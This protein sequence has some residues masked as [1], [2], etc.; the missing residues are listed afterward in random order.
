MSYQTLVALYATAAAASSAAG[1]L[2]TAGIPRRDIDLRSRDAG[3]TTASM[4][5]TLES[6]QEGT[7]FWNWLL[8]GDRPQHEAAAYSDALERGGTAV[9]VR[10]EE[11]RADEVIA[12][13]EGHDPVDIDAIADTTV[14]APSTTGA[15]AAGT[16]ASGLASPRAED[17]DA[18]LQVVEEQLR[19]GKRE[20][21]GGRVRV[22][23]YVV[24][25][26]VEEQVELRQERVTI[27]RRPVNRELRPGDAAFQEQTIEAVERGEEAVV[28]KTARVVEEVGLRKDVEQEKQVLRDTVRRQEVEVEDDRTTRG[29]LASGTGAAG[30][31]RV[32]TSRSSTDR[33][34][35]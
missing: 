15:M 23:S 6:R 28:S 30:T 31:E 17:G 5:T 29:D 4:T 16:A 2:E 20:V 18:P 21:A 25:R 35:D 34:I 9:S 14:A 26:P 13:M 7:G 3:G 12:I 1:D 22:R 33:A 24:E 19:V 11:A 8:G 10:V 27:E 32:E